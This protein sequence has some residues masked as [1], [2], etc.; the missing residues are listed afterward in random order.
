VAGRHRDKSEWAG[1]WNHWAFTKDIRVGPEGEKGRMEI[2]LNGELYDSLTGTDTPITGITSFE[3]G[4]GWYGYYDGR[5]DDFQIFDY[6]LAPAE[7][8]YVATDGTGVFRHGSSSPA[9]LDASGLVDLHDFSILATQ[10]LQDGLW[11]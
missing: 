10:W 11:P 3:I 1:R 2:Y 4:S 8:A 5:I 9:D 7:I 6:A